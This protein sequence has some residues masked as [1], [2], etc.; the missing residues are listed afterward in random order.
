MRQIPVETLKSLGQL[1][2]N[3]ADPNAYNLARLQSIPRETRLAEQGQ[4]APCC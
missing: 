3:L 4:E 2:R 1:P